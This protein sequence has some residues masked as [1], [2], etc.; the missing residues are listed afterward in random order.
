[1]S[2]GS[3]INMTEGSTKKLILKF[4]YPIF[5][6]QLLQQLYNTVD[7]AIVG[8]ALGKQALAAVTSSGT[9]IFL[10]ISFFVGTTMGAGVVISRYFGANDEENMS[11]AIHTNV[12][13]GLLCGVILT[14]VGIFATPT[15]LRW[16]GTDPDVLPSSII[17]F[18]WYFVGGLSIVMYNTLRSVMNAVGD[19]RRPLYF[20]IISAVLNIVLDLLFVITFKM[21]VAGAAIATTISQT[22]SAILCLITLLKERTSCRLYIKKIKLHLPLVKEIVRYGLPSGVQNSVIALANVIVQSC[23]NSFGEDA[24]AGYGSH[25]KVE[26]FVFLPITCF[27]MALTTFISQNL[28]AKKYERAK[29]GA[30]FGIIASALIAEGIGVLVYFL[31]PYILQI[32]SDDP[33]VLAYGVQQAR[34][35]C[36]FY[37]LLAFSHSIA[38]ICRGAGKAFVPMIVMLSVWCVIRIIYIYLVMYLLPGDI[39]WVYWAYPLTWFISSVIYLIYYLKS[40]W[41]HGY[42]QESR[43]KNVFV[44]HH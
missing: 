42:E 20:L 25:A 10:L 17:Y 2:N 12:A 14:I 26:G 34:T 3:M 37:C 29:E 36:F 5:L 23:I 9:L 39:K 6:S 24:M 33:V 21:G 35:L 41:V 27:T 44:R 19:S 28:G 1:M 4:A 31:A 38:S 15:I 8:R 16:M 32:F 13:L 11:K 40:D 30:R 18:R 43:L 7:A 22:V